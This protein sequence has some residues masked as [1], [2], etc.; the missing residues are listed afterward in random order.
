M[1]LG[2]G[3]ALGRA[4]TRRAALTAALFPALEPE[5]VSQWTTATLGARVSV[6]H[7]RCAAALLA[8]A[9]RWRA[10]LPLRQEEMEGAP[11]S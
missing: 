8:R 9:P 4:R 11:G 10:V 6:A 5:R 3:R 1:S 2:A 7:W